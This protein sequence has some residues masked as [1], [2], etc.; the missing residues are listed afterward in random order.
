MPLD[1]AEDWDLSCP[2]WAE[3]LREGRSLVPDLPQLDLS[4]AA[5]AVGIFDKLCLYDVVG[6][7][8]MKE[9]AGDWWRDIMRALFGSLDMATG[10]RRIRGLFCL[11]PKK[12]AKT[13]NAA[14]LMLTALIM[15]KR[16]AAEMLL[17][18]PSQEISDKAFN[19]VR[20][21]IANDPDNYL[22]KRFHVAN[23]IKTITDRTN[24]ALLK[25]KT[26]DEDIV[27][28]AVVA[29]AAID[30]IHLLG[31][32]A[33]AAWII[34]QIRGGMITIP[35][36]FFA[37]ITTQSFEPPAG[38][39]RDELKIARAVRDGTV[40]G[41]DTLPV[42][43][44]FT[45][46]QQKDRKFW[47]NP[48]NWP[49][50]T[51]NL[52]RS[53]RI[54]RLVKDFAEAQLKDEKDVRI[55]ASQH[56]N[57]EIGLALH[58]ERWRGADYWEAATFEPISDLAEL[59]KRSEVVTMG[60]DGGGLDDLLGLAVLGR[61]KATR[62]WLL[63]TH[64]WCHESVLNLRQ[65]EAPLFR[66]FAAD[67]DLGIMAELGE[68]LEEVTEITRQVV[69]SGKLPAKNAVGLDAAGLGGLLDAILSGGVRQDQIVGVSQGWRLSGAIMTAERALA[70]GTLVHAGRRLMAY[71]VGNA[72]VE[73]RGSAKLITKQGSG[74]GKIDPLM[75]TFDAV[76]LM[77]LNPAARGTAS[78]TVL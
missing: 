29:A 69:A 46:A 37:M 45:E 53:I 43:Y 42:L 64:A 11:V 48:S 33:R 36:S 5:R 77:S 2:D 12:N 14:G 21:M 16:P 25:V 23:H 59:L 50:V 4:I 30:E 1:Q 60:G 67:G 62:R 13:T 56:L 74:V 75:A 3:R 31:R 38:V 54:P 65:S 78:I 61:E 51:P 44:E 68:D 63:W 26:F 20:G 76:S 34:Q 39:F 27:T 55:W 35:E 70:D 15:N 28:G 49:L 22:Q 52:N 73:P 40:K 66:Q 47:E 58:S 17:T 19:T 71:C 72:K 57:I 32:N 6:T 7:P 8:A 24:D 41:V 10:V 18:G 9:V